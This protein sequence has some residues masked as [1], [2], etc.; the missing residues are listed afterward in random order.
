ML[1]QMDPDPLKLGFLCTLS[2][3]LHPKIKPVLAYRLQQHDAFTVLGNFSP[4][5]KLGDEAVNI[6]IRL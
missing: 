3:T 4:D 2:Q 1:N 5:S 6:R